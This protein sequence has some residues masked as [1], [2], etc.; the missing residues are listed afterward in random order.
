MFSNSAAYIST[1]CLL[2][3]MLKPN[4]FVVLPAGGKVRQI[5]VMGG[6]DWHSCCI[7]AIA[8]W[9]LSQTTKQ[10]VTLAFTAWGQT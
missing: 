1:S 7:R 4:W 2:A 6:A 8:C 10:P 9:E 5:V 3:S